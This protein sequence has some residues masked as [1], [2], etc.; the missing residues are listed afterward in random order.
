MLHFSDQSLAVASSKAVSTIICDCYDPR[1]QS[2]TKS[3]G[4][5]EQARDDGALPESQLIDYSVSESAF[6]WPCGPKSRPSTGGDLELMWA[7]YLFQIIVNP[8]NVSALVDH[9][10]ITCSTILSKHLLL[11]R[12][13]VFTC[14]VRGDEGVSQ[15]KVEEMTK[16]KPIIT[17]LL[18]KLC[19]WK[20][21]A[22]IPVA[23]HGALFESIGGISE[24][25]NVVEAQANPSEEI[26]S[27][28]AVLK[29][30]QLHLMSYLERICDE[31]L[32]KGLTNPLRFPVVAQHTTLCLLNPTSAVDQS[33]KRYIRSPVLLC[34]AFAMVSATGILIASS[35]AAHRLLAHVAAAKNAPTQQQTVMESCLVAV[36]RNTEAFLRGMLSMLQSFRLYDFHLVV[37]IPTLKKIIFVWT[38]IFE[39]L[40][41][42]LLKI[43]EDTSTSDSS[44]ATRGASAASSVNLQKL[45]ILINDFLVSLLS[46]LYSP[47]KKP[48]A[49]KVD[50]SVL[51]RILDFAVTFWVFWT[52]KMKDKNAATKRSAGLIVSLVRC[53]EFGSLAEKPRAA[54]LL[55]IVLETLLRGGVALD[56]NALRHVESVK[57]V[58]SSIESKRSTD[59]ARVAKKFRQ[60]DRASGFFNKKT[61]IS[62]WRVSRDSDGTSSAVA[63]PAGTSSTADPSRPPKPRKHV[64]EII[65]LTGTSKTNL[66]SRPMSAKAAARAHARVEVDLTGFT[67]M[68][69]EASA[70]KNH[71]FYTE[72]DYVT[73]RTRE[74]SPMERDAKAKAKTTDFSMSQVIRGMAHAHGTANQP[75]YA[76]TA[77]KSEDR[78]A[79]QKQAQQ[80]KEEEAQDEALQFAGL[81]HR[82]KNTQKPIPVC[83]LLPFY[84]QL[85]QLCMPQLLTREFENERSDK[86]LAPPDLTFKRSSEY[87]NAYLPLLV[88]ESN[89]ELQEGLRKFYSS[90]GGHLLRYES[91]KPREGMR[92]LNFTIAEVDESAVTQS[93]FFKNRNGNRGTPKDKVF[94]N[95]DVVL[96][97]IVNSENQSRSG[98]MGNRELIGIVLISEVEKSKKH[99]T[100]NKKPGENDEEESVKVLFLNDGELDSVTDEVGSFS[101]ETLSASAIADSE[102]KVHCIANLTTSAREYISLRSV[103]MLPEHLR[104]TILT[105]NVYKSTQTELILITTALDDLRSSRS[106]DANAKILKLLKRLDKMDV[107]LMDL[108]VRSAYVV[109]DDD[110]FGSKH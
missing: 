104:T 38:K 54:E 81:F 59:F 101:V 76:R 94:R 100:P 49:V 1:L 89:N 67:K 28:N 44:K 19:A 86:V 12:D 21:I 29:Q 102:W 75:A 25:L 90:G 2:A 37:A 4:K 103:D 68:S 106:A 30:Y 17:G 87:V 20:A 78:A 39:M 41:A 99:V 11:A 6:W 73:P 50:E 88:E 3:G 96:M 108:R 84:R 13:V 72:S 18:G 55:M 35:H 33:I 92:C 42:S 74:P 40:G 26:V 80:E 83:S 85:L 45:P 48:D 98:F 65:D 60:L 8:E 71:S 32:V 47:N 5:K 110:A 51:V 52:E 95:G 24:I 61:T 63:A 36:H 82:I 56:D 15:K 66:S 27:F 16:S 53:I 46:R 97:R 79:Q 23:V 109:V 34:Y 93:F 43:L 64:Q 91:E 70:R 69:E 105:P 14:L 62:E 57:S 9:A 107:T 22:T 58:S 31:V 7:T 10:A 77:T